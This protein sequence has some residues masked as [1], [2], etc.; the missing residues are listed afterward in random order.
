MN[1]LPTSWISEKTGLGPYGSII[2]VRSTLS[3]WK[4]KWKRLPLQKKA[5]VYHQNRIWPFTVVDAGNM[6]VNKTQISLPSGNGGFYNLTRLYRVWSENSPRERTYQLKRSSYPRNLSG[7]DAALNVN[8]S[9]CLLAG[10]IKL[11]QVKILQL[12]PLGQSLHS[13]GSTWIHYF[14]FPMDFLHRIDL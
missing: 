6:A 9:P 1:S 7:G 8:E 14:P 12:T 5:T 11:S 4:C 13:S 2:L 3:G 10:A